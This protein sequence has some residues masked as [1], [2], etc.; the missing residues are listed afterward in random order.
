MHESLSTQQL[1]WV[2]G[3]SANSI[4]DDVKSGDIEST[5]IPSGFRIPKAEVLRLAPG[6]RGW[7]TL[8]AV[9]DREFSGRVVEIGASALPVT[10]TG[11]AG[12]ARS[13]R[14]SRPGGHARL[15]RPDWLR[16]Q[17]PWPADRLRRL[18]RR[19]RP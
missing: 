18:V 19:P 9:P 6:Q 7:V 15:L 8:E 13:Q 11:A 17:R 10:G 12:H 2:L 4:R 1:G 5:R 14:H 16:R 3:R